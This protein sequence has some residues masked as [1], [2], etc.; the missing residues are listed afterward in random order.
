MKFGSKNGKPS[1]EEGSAY[2]AKMHKKIQQKMA[3]KKSVS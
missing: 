1:K 3:K 2:N